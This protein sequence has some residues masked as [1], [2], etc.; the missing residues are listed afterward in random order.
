MERKGRERHIY[1]Q[2]G[3]ERRIDDNKEKEKWD[4]QVE[5]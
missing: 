2:K 4:R 5:N 1:T 3:E